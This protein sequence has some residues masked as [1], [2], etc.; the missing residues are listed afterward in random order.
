M[1]PD[2]PQKEI[3]E[4]SKHGVAFR[5]LKEEMALDSS[6]WVLGKDYF[7]APTCATC[8]VS[9]NTRNGGRVTH[10]PGFRLSWTNRPAVSQVM[11]T[12]LNGK[13]VTE[14][15]PA[16]RQSLIADTAEAK[17]NRMKDVC[18]HCHTGDY[19]NG[20]YQQ[21]DELVILYN[22]K[23]AKPGQAII[24]ALKKAEL[25]TKAD[26]D[27]EIEWTWYYLW[28]HEGRRARMGASMLG[29]D[30]TH[31]HGMFEVGDRFYMQLIPQ[32]REIVRKAAE[33]GK[34]EAA[35]AVGA[36]IDEVLKRPEHAWSARSLSPGQKQG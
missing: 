14:T 11:D 20:F 30:Y 15:D 13:V 7:Q 35:R 22:E 4:E 28:H 26:F 16:A 24:A 10:D 9:G 18:L 31:W 19:V 27:E 12:D 2:H 29:P 3:F 1:G 32:A 17:R 25:L 21:Y 23:F 34:A 33:S 6:S 5:D 36:V 8:H